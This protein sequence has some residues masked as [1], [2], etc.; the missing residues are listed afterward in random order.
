MVDL[1]LEEGPPERW[2]ADRRTK[3]LEPGASD[4]GQRV[5]LGLG[6]VELKG[7]AATVEEVLNLGE[8]LVVRREDVDVVEIGQQQAVRAEVAHEVVQRPPN[9]DREEERAERITLP[10]PLRRLEYV[11]RPIRTGDGELSRRAVDPAAGPVESRSKV[12]QPCRKLAPVDGVEGV[13]EV[14]RDEVAVRL[15]EVISERPFD[16]PDDRLDAARPS[17][18]HR[19]EPAAACQA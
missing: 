12:A 1:G 19:A 10:H 2:T 11:D 9:G 16:C 8:G 7:R 15:G 3:E 13:R 17:N 6:D 5:R 14:E 18:R 4:V